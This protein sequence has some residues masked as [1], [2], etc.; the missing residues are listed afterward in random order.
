MAVLHR[1]HSRDWFAY[2]SKKLPLPETAWAQI[3]DL[4]P[5]HA[6]VFASQ[7]RVAAVHDAPDQEDGQARAGVVGMGRNHVFRMA[8]RP[9]IT[10][11]RGASR[12]NS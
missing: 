9:R 8:I 7:H 5:G 4:P 12:V 6:M 10:A 1:F 11:D 2:L 3:Q